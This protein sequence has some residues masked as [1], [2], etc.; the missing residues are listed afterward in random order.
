VFIPGGPLVPGLKSLDYVI[1]N[2]SRRGIY[3]DLKSISYQRI[4]KSQPPP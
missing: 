4:D 1:F 2:G 3:A